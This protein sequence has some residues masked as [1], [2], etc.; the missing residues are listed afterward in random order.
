MVFLKQR[1]KE[2]SFIKNDKDED[3]D[4]VVYLYYIRPFIPFRCVQSLC[5]ETINH[6]ESVPKQ[7]EGTY[8]RYVLEKLARTWISDDPVD[9]DWFDDKRI[10]DELQQDIVAML[11]SK[12]VDVS[13]S[14]KYFILLFC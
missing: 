8:P 13:S 14:G 10:Y 12:F 5:F 7:R 6:I 11:E 4:G 3:E 2:N 1:Y 9:K